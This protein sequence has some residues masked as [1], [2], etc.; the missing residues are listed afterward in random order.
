M[1]QAIRNVE[2]ALGDGIKRPSPS[3]SKNIPIVRKSLVASMP[4]SKGEL[5]TVDNLTVKRPGTGIPPRLAHLL[6]GRRT[7]EAIETDDVITWDKLS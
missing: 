7:S 2:I 5:F 4:I 1:V 3:E 6:A